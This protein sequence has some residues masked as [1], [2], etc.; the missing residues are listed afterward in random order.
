MTVEFFMTMQNLI[1]SYKVAKTEEEKTSISDQ[2]WEEAC[3]DD[4]DAMSYFSKERWLAT[5]FGIEHAPMSRPKR[6]R[7]KPKNIEFEKAIKEFV[8]NVVTDGG[9]EPLDDEEI[10]AWLEGAVRYVVSTLSV[11]LSYKQRKKVPIEVNRVQYVA[12]CKV[13]SI[14]P[15]EIGKPIDIESAKT[16]KR[17]LVRQLHPDA[18]GGNAEKAQLYQD[19]VTAFDI[20]EQYAVEMKKRRRRGPDKLARTLDRAA[21]RAMRANGAILP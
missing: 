7:R 9:M 6:R 18:T 8:A 15:S 17:A 20:I 12:A 19:V 2:I 3:K 5:L 13:L 11:K 4:P 21:K 10:Q 14:Q 1:E 16:S